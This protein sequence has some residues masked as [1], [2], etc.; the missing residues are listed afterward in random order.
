VL[1]SQPEATS[2]DY[3]SLEDGYDEAE[4][5]R[6]AEDFDAEQRYEGGEMRASG[7]YEGGEMRPV[8][9]FSSAGRATN[10]AMAASSSKAADFSSSAGVL[11]VGGADGAGV[12]DDTDGVDGEVQTSLQELLGGDFDLRRAVIEAEILTPKYIARY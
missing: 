10:S 11:S 5:Y 8:G 6:S 3:Q 1:A 9:R 2:L 7:R 4:Y 12:T